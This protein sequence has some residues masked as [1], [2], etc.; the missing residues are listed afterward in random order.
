ML[1]PQRTAAVASR[2]AGEASN[3]P[4]D[5][6]RGHPRRLAVLRL[7]G[8]K[9]PLPPPFLV[10][11]REAASPGVSA[12]NSGPGILERGRFS[13]LGREPAASCGLVFWPVEL[14]PVLGR[15]CRA[16]ARSGSGSEAGGPS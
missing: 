1:S 2:G 4:G 3:F 11:R 13:S 7:R 10:W 9:P 16:V 15:A 5:P 8:D 14:R 12:R 6:L